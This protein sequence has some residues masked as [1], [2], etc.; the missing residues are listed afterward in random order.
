MNNKVG[1]GGEG[2]LRRKEPV[3]NNV[4]IGGEGGV[5]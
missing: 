1:M 4:G 2:G 3:N 5:W